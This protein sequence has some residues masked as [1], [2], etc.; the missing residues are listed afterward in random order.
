[1][2][3]SLYYLKVLIVFL[4]NC[5]YFLKKGEYFR[6]KSLAKILVR[7]LYLIIVKFNS[8]NRSPWS[9]KISKQQIS[10]F[11]AV[12]VYDSGQLQK[13]YSQT[14]GLYEV[15]CQKSGKHFTYSLIIPVYQPKPE[16][17]YTLLKS[18]L[19]QSIEHYEI[20][21]GLDG[22]QPKEV[23]D[24]IVR[25]RSE[26]PD[27]AKRLNILQFN[28]DQQKGI[29]MTSNSL[30]SAAKGDYLVF[31]DHDDWVRPD[32]LY[33]YDLLLRYSK[34]PSNVCLYCD[35]VKIDEYDNLVENSYLR[36][37]SE[38]PFPYIFV[39]WV[40]HC[41]LVP[42]AAFVKA[43]ALSS[44]FDGAQDFELILKLDTYGL[45]F[46]KCPVPLY[47]WRV[48]SQSTSADPNS[49][50]YADAAGV[51]ALQSYFA[52][53]GLNWAVESGEVSTNYF[54]R[55]HLSEEF[56]KDRSV[57]VVIPFKDEIELTR[58][59]L[60]SLEK[61]QSCSLYITLINNNSKNSEINSIIQS[62]F[63]QKLNLEILNINEPFNFSRLC[64]LGAWHS[65]F[66]KT[67]EILFMNNDV[68]LNR[69]AILEM[70]RWIEQ[71][72]IGAVGCR[73]LYPNNTIQHGGVDLRDDRE[74][75][76]MCWSHSSHGLEFSIAG[77]HSIQR[78]VDAVTAA[79]VLVKRT[80]F[81]E[82]NGFDEDFYPIAFSDTDICAR[83]QKRGKI[84]F[85]N[86]LAT[87]IHYESVTRGK[88]SIEDFEASRELFTNRVGIRPD[89]SFYYRD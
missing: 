19:L 52:K 56:L 14:K 6:L 27:F 24:V 71:P 13:L 7:D 47:A 50:S 21:I 73:L 74:E 31:I 88:N 75:F 55:P 11:S 81:D 28:R 4:I 87:G 1:M 44:E 76:K 10:M 39:N 5:I 83:I 2:N 29:S 41:L 79:C 77:A 25:L 58:K 69:N 8:R 22:K 42:K 40:C 36:K 64:N 15:Q 80:S 72:R 86:P 26:F 48:H 84:V 20:M 43:G 62:E 16:H 45:E 23:E 66:N 59:A 18:C 38:V 35:E 51:R 9:K 67:S 49:K 57:Q 85:Y 63:S 17:F 65:K 34:D 32:L 3:K 82:I 60:K 53:K 70:L 37:P 33:R 68:E 46:K 61:Q 12:S 30:A 89:S 78:P 54:V